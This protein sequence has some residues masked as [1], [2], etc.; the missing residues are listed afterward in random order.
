MSNP[1]LYRITVNPHVLAG[2]PTIRGLRL[3]VEH[4]LCALSSGQTPDELME[5]YP[6]LEPE[7]FQAIL[8]YAADRVA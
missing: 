4:L 1:I 7:D 2:K 8:A 6:E 3:S 5:E